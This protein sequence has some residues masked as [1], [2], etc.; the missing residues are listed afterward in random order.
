M[1]Q[2]SLSVMGELI[3]Y[4]G[5]LGWNALFTN[6]YIGVSAADVDYEAYIENMTR[7]D[8]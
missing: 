3:T 7:S 5:N 6:I 8:V 4:L 1:I 2:C